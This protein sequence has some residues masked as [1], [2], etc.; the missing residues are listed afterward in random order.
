MF[1]QKLTIKIGQ[2][3]PKELEICLCSAPYLLA[4]VASLPLVNPL[5][6]L[7]WAFYLEKN[8]LEGVK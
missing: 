6:A 1:C 3:L 7:R 5:V 4:L 2:H 8:F